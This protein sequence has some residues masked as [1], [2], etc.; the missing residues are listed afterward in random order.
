MTP[1]TNMPRTCVTRMIPTS[2]LAPWFENKIVEPPTPPQTNWLGPLVP[3]VEKLG[4]LFEV[5]SSSL[6]SKVIGPIIPREPKIRMQTGLQSCPPQL[7]ASGLS[8]LRVTPI[9]AP[10]RTPAVNPQ[11]I[12]DLVLPRKQPTYNAYKIHTVPKLISYLYANAG[13]LTKSFISEVRQKGFL[14]NMTRTYHQ[15]RPSPSPTQEQE[16]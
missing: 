14:C 3:R 4:R 13:F 10:T 9:G 6:P 16:Y 2:K 7:T 5:P 11:P 15:P 1:T 12:I 8:V